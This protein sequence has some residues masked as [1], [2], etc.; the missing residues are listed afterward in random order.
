MA[1]DR[2][3]FV[4]HGRTAS[5]AAGAWQGYLDTPLDDVGLLEARAAADA[6][7]PAV[8]PTRLVS[9]DLKRAVAT[10]QPFADAWGLTVQTDPI[11]R[12][13]NAGAWEGLSR[14]EIESRWPED[15]A[16]WKAGEDVRIGGAERMSEAGARVA[17]RVGELM[18]EGEGTLVI[19]SHGGVTRMATLELAGM[20]SNG[21]ALRTM[22]NAHWAVLVRGLSGELSLDGWNL[23]PT[24]SAAPPAMP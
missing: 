4:R 3:I 22:R 2:L 18:D 7:C 13:V 17:G 11:L 23:G 6:L 9:S 10:A 15:L 14:N 5:N 12:E 19:V 16:A 24:V 1:C 21:R 8:A 20:G